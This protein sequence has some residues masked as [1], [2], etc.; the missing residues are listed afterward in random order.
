M[1]KSRYTKRSDGRYQVK[2]NVGKSAEGKT[3]YKTLYGST[4]RE[5]KNKEAAL[6]SQLAQ[7]V[8]ID[9]TN[10]T[11]AQWSKEWLSTYKNNVAYNT[12]ASYENIVEKHIVSSDIAGMKI[13]DI[14]LYHL[15]QLINQKADMGLTRTL[16][17]LKCTL[18]Q[19]F[20][21]A[22]NNDMLIKNPTRG[23]EL[24]KKERKEKRALTDDERRAIEK[25]DFTPKQKT[26]VYIGLYAGLR[27]GEILALTKDDIDF[28]NHTISVNKNLVFKKSGAE[29]KNSPKTDAG[30]RSVPIQKILYDVLFEYVSGLQSSYLFTM[31]DEISLMTS[32]SYRRFWGSIRR[33][34][35][36]SAKENKLK[37]DTSSLTAHILRHTFATDLFYSGIDM[38]AAQKILGHSKI[39]VTMDTYTHCLTSNDEVIKKLNDHNTPKRE[40][41]PCPFCGS[42]ASFKDTNENSPY[43]I[44]CESCGLEFGLGKNYNQSEIVDA[45]NRRSFG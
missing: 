44:A 26:F 15:Q 11:L 19:I 16:E 28:N 3:I 18:V 8:I 7:G 31:N 17:L 20:E 45:W 12:Y 21:S 4:E 6:Q 25:A 41:S 36:A 23:L 30:L 24:P 35:D 27:R 32:D 37:V 13:K 40:L 34:I 2:V 22:I 1:P 10:Q 14:K 43:L 39:E 33:D 5:L 42:V 9:N 38:K 29:I